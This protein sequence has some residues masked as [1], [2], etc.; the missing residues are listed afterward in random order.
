MTVLP[1]KTYPTLVSKRW[2]TIAELEEVFSRNLL[3]SHP[4]V[5]GIDRKLVLKL[6]DRSERAVA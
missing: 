3:V 4:R 5:A 6:L 2:K 1:L